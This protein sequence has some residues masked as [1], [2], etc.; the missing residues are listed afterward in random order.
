MNRYFIILCTLI[1][2][3]NVFAQEPIVDEKLEKTTYFL[4]RHAEKVRL[5]P[6]DKNPHLNKKG[7]KRAKAWKDML[8]HFNIE[9]IYSTEYNRTQET[10]DLLAK[11]LALNINTYH[12]FNIDMEQFLKSTKGKNV[13]VVGHSNTTPGFA[14]KLIGQEVYPDIADD[15]NANLY[16]VTLEGNKVSHV[17]IKM[18]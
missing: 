18:H 13:L 16:I 3:A 14:N 7:K 11:H 2:T 1:L 5:D 6:K 9:Q 15:N 10:A 8:L 12:P 4:I 17:L